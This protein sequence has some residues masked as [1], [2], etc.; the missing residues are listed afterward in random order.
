MFV[1]T[2]KCINKKIR[3]LTKETFLKS[4]KPFQIL[5]LIVINKI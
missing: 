4:F 1:K 5:I 3:V 2:G